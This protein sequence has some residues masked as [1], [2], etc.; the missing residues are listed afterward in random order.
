MEGSPACSGCV[1][2]GPPNGPIV[3]PPQTAHAVN[4]H[5]VIPAAPDQEY[6]NSPALMPRLSTREQNHRL[7]PAIT[8]TG[9]EPINNTSE[10][11]IT[12]PAFSPFADDEGSGGRSYADGHFTAVQHDGIDFDDSG[13]PR[14]VVQDNSTSPVADPTHRLGV[15]TREP[16]ASQQTAEKASQPRSSVDMHYRLE[17]DLAEL[18][19][20]SHSA[21]LDGPAE[22][23]TQYG[24]T[25]PSLQHTSNVSPFA[26]GPESLQLP[27]N[28]A[29]STSNFDPHIEWEHAA[30]QGDYYRFLYETKRNE[31][32][33]S[34]LLEWMQGRTFY[35]KNGVL[36]HV[37]QH[38]LGVFVSSSDSDLPL[39]CHEIDPY[40]WTEVWRHRHLLTSSSGSKSIR[41]RVFVLDDVSLGAIE[42][43]GRATGLDPEVLCTHLARTLSYSGLGKA[44]DVMQIPLIHRREGSFS[45]SFSLPL[46]PRVGSAHPWAYDSHSSSTLH[47]VWSFDAPAETLCVL[48][49][50][51]IEDKDINFGRLGDVDFA[52][53]RRTYMKTWLDMKEDVDNERSRYEN[54]DGKAYR[55][56][57]SCHAT[58]TFVPE[59]SI[60]T[61][62]L[63]RSP[64]QW[65]PTYHPDKKISLHQTSS[66]YGLDPLAGPMFSQESLALE[67]R[68]PFVYQALK[69]CRKAELKNDIDINTETI[70]AAVSIST[71]HT[72]TQSFHATVARDYS[73]VVDLFEQ[74]RYRKA[75]VS[76]RTENLFAFFSPRC[77]R[78]RLS[79]TARL[80]QLCTIRDVA[81][82]THPSLHLLSKLQTIT[83]LVNEATTIIDAT[84]TYLEDRKES[85]FQGLQIE[86]TN[87]QI[88]ESRY[89]LDRNESVRRITLL[90][91]IFIP[92]SAVTGFFGMNVAE[93]ADTAIWKFG[94]TMGAILGAT[95]ILAYADSIHA[96]WSTL[97]WNILTATHLESH[98]TFGNFFVLRPL[99]SVLWVIRASWG[100]IRKKVRWPL[101]RWIWLGKKLNKEENTNFGSLPRNRVRLD[102]ALFDKRNWQESRKWKPDYWENEHRKEIEV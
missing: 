33:V 24:A 63:L 97:R 4:P 1:W 3:T 53:F 19:S 47:P 70:F 30:N 26:S 41:S 29:A 46:D 22:A 83:N 37:R 42:L 66:L 86:L 56:E 98:N 5:E 62:I 82:R 91:F 65:H 2:R 32:G 11:P 85:Y 61:I 80:Q 38:C 54:V 8:V 10:S 90:A 75:R 36:Q 79:A 43:I 96:L 15:D 7:P 49:K 74:V 99:W 57:F 59:S 72:V 21:D 89:A 102:P 12:Y 73:D 81:A 27:Q 84:T 93:L 25:S 16:S 6:Q 20:R 69:A 94:A 23:S 67:S 52:V 9:P 78:H 77:A 68:F 55:T 71:L 92:I 14:A 40:D 76:K 60:P 87:I 64:T 88:A 45:E 39:Q 101:G 100:W 31:P 44:P 48:S 51:D 17:Q 28:S 13:A 34:I 95:L 50:A 35:R 58:M 18:A